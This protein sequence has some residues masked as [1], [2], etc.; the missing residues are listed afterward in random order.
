MISKPIIEIQRGCTTLSRRS[1][2]FTGSRDLATPFKGES[3]ELRQYSFTKH[4]PVRYHLYLVDRSGET[5]A[6]RTSFRDYLKD[7]RKSAD[8][9]AELKQELASRYPDDV[10]AYQDGKL[11]FVE[12]I[13]SAAKGRAGSAS[14]N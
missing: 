11:E 5:W 10:R 6:K 12:R 3:G 1:A 7:N 13:V 9:Y 2:A 8:S 4:D 14:R